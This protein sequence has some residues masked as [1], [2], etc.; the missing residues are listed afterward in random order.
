MNIKTSFRDVNNRDLRTISSVISHAFDDE[1]DFRDEEI[2]QSLLLKE[3]I[4]GGH[5]IVS[6]VAEEYENVRHVFVSPVS[7][8]PANGLIF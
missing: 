1:Q 7:L 2:I 8:A 6:L 4:K 3:P 5:D